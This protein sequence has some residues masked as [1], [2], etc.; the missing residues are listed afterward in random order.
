[1]MFLLLC[2]QRAYCTNNPQKY[3]DFRPL[4]IVLVTAI[5]LAPVSRI[6]A[7]LLLEF[8]F[9]AYSDVPQKTQTQS[10]IGGYRLSLNNT[11]NTPVSLLDGVGTSGSAADKSLNLTSAS[12]MGGNS[13]TPVGPVATYVANTGAVIP[14]QSSLTISGWFKTHGSTPIGNAARIFEIGSLSVTCPHDGVLSFFVSDGASSASL[15]SFGDYLLTGSWCFFAIT[16]DG[17]IPAGD[18]VCFYVGSATTP[19]TLVGCGRIELFQWMG[20]PN[21]SDNNVIRIGNVASGSSARGRP[22]DGY[23]DNISLYG[24]ASGGSG[25]LILS[26]IENLRLSTCP[27]VSPPAIIVP[28]ITNAHPRL[29][30]NQ[31]E[32]STMWSRI[33]AGDTAGPYAA[34]WTSHSNMVDGYPSALTLAPYLGINPDKLYE[35]TIGWTGSEPDQVGQARFARDCA[36][37]YQCARGVSSVEKQEGYATKAIEIL[38]EWAS[39]HLCDIFDY[40]PSND[41]ITD[42]TVLPLTGYSGS[43]GRPFSESTMSFLSDYSEGRWEYTGPA[44]HGGH[45]AIT[46]TGTV[47]SL[48]GE[49]VPQDAPQPD[50]LSFR[51]GSAPSSSVGAQQILLLAN[52][53][54]NVTFDAASTLSTNVRRTSNTTGKVRVVVK[55]NGQWYIS[56]TFKSIDGS[57]TT[58]LQFSNLDSISWTTYSPSTTLDYVDSGVA[59]FSLANGAIEEA[60]LFYQQNFTASTTSWTKALIISSIGIKATAKPG[61]QFDLSDPVN[62]HTY[63]PFMARGIISFCYAYDL[64]Y[65]YNGTGHLTPADKINIEDWFQKLACIIKPALCDWQTFDYMRKMYHNNHLA[66]CIAGVTAIG[67][68]IGDRDL[69]QWAIETTDEENPRDWTTQLSGLILKPSD[70]PCSR[71]AST[72][73]PPHLGEIYDRYRHRTNPNRGLRYSH[74]SMSLISLV[75]EMVQHNGL[76]LWNYRSATGETLRQPWEFYSDFYRLKTALINDNPPGSGKFFYGGDA[77]GNYVPYNPNIPSDESRLIRHSVHFGDPVANFELALLHFRD[78]ST[79]QDLI[80]SLGSDRPTEVCEEYLGPVVLTH[81]VPNPADF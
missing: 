46:T 1:M 51:V 68:A 39:P 28:A 64:L 12:Q 19:V 17:S 45:T 60:G 41:Y 15:S 70:A 69:V 58:P 22:L 31:S 34:A 23:L 42:A 7:D 5:S 6:H 21:V 77:S 38:K 35:Y 30:I 53:S 54:A 29:F 44:F 3:M 72:A 61:T 50:L 56:R 73:P 11:A 71:E 18:N 74:L 16:F 26:D 79:L 13:T 4:V 59:D 55:Q 37:A 20:L 78:S 47:S 27:M 65:N 24:A 63:G 75:A 25:A 80:I 57:G 52:V 14:A 48:I 10:S 66:A 43:S 36:I 76:D 67:Y 9:D 2:D 49:T 32:I 62:L 8:K 33:L 40:S 81:G